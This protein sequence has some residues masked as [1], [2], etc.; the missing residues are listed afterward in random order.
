MIWSIT[1]FADDDPIR[2]LEFK[3]TDWDYMSNF[4]KTV[5]QSTK[6]N[7]AVTIMRKEISTTIYDARTGER[8]EYDV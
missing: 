8:K 1:V 3:F 5:F 4:L 2:A 7:I 6:D